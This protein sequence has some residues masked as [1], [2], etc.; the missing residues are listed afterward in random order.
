MK[1]YG[2]ILLLFFCL[3]PLLVLAPAT[4]LAQSASP[5]ECTTHPVLP[6]YRLHRSIPLADAIAEQPSKAGGNG[7]FYLNNVFVAMEHSGQRILLSSSENGEDGFVT[8]DILHLKTSPANKERSW[9]FRSSDHMR[10]IP[11]DAAQE[12]TDLFTP[13]SLNLMRVTLI[14]ALAPV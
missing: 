4:T 1:H 11:I 14:D 2:R 8:D 10:I 6:G 13:G 3:L 9:D 7:E 5:S 12:I